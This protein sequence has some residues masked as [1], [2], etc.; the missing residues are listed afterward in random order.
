MNL[1]TRTC[2]ISL[3]PVAFALYSHSPPHRTPLPIDKLLAFHFFKL[4]FR[5]ENS[6]CMNLSDATHIVDHKSA[7]NGLM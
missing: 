7:F 1:S 4:S 5:S 3:G 6:A 2:W